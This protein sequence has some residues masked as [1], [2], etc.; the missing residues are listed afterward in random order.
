MDEVANYRL[1]DSGRL[2]RIVNDWNRNTVTVGNIQRL[3]IEYL[4]V[5]YVGAM[6]VQVM[7]DRADSQTQVVWQ[8][9][10][11]IRGPPSTDWAGLEA[12]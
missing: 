10:A 12:S 5:I 9:S 6:C 3:G 11:A 2:Q 1:D 4:Q 8:S 7:Q